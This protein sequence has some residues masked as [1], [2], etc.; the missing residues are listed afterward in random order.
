MVDL[1]RSDTRHRFLERVLKDF[2]AEMTEERGNILFMQDGAPSHRDGR[3]K[4]WL[5]DHN[6]PLLFHPPSS[7]DLNPIEPVWHEVKKI[8]RALPKQP[9]SVKAL[10][11]A[12][13]QAWKALPIKDIN[14]Y[15]LRLWEIIVV[16]SKGSKEVTLAIKYHLL[17]FLNTKYNVEHRNSVLNKAVAEKAAGVYKILETFAHHKYNLGP[18]YPPSIRLT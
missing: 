17:Y 15:T 12:I 1:T 2:H 3:T 14:K 4:E 5:R 18:E 6:I 16:Q 8:I 7:P 10:Q 13:H 11:E 9:G